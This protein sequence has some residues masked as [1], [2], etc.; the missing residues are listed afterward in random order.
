M[1]HGLRRMG[2]RVAESNPVSH[3]WHSSNTS[4]RLWP[5]NPSNSSVLPPI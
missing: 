5:L 1:G 2:T 3:H 4:P